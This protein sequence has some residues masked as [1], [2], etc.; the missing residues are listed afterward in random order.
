MTAT[1]EPLDIIPV[2][3]KDMVQRCCADCSKHGRS[4]VD[5]KMSGRNQSAQQKTG[6]ELLENIDHVTD[7]TFPVHGHKD[8]EKYRGGYGYTPLIESSG[9]A[10]VVVRDKSKIQSAMFNSVLRSLCIFVVPLATSY[11]AGFIIWMLVSKR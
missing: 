7:F 1:G 8:Q 4:A 2:V 11:V 3:L 6:R 9:V 5:F 10:F